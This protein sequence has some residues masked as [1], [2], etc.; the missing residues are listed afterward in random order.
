MSTAT[1]IR[2][3][4]IGEPTVAIL[5]Q[6]LADERAHAETLEREV[7]AP[8][9]AQS[10][11]ELRHARAALMHLSLHA[12]QLEVRNALLVDRLHRLAARHARRPRWQQACRWL[13]VRL[14]R[15]RIPANEY[16][17]EL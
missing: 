10:E 15:E 7:Y 5:R 9:L 2:A 11:T 4:G 6:Q 3:A 14:R 13:R 17:I 16:I 8:A 12:E 1:T